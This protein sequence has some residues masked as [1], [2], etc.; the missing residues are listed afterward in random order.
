MPYRV[1]FG[2]SADASCFFGQAE[3]CV[4]SVSHVVV[5][6]SLE[7]MCKNLSTHEDKHTESTRL[8]KQVGRL[9]PLLLVVGVCAMTLCP[10][11]CV[12]RDSLHVYMHSTTR[13][14]LCKPGLTSG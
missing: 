7:A 2:R 12:G 11:I 14:A 10:H 13:L 1:K 3:S 4:V 8:L 9:R 5:P 6:L